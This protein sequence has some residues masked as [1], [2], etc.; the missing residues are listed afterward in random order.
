MFFLLVTADAKHQNSNSQLKLNSSDKKSLER[1]RE[2]KCENKTP[3]VKLD[4]YAVFNCDI[5]ECVLV[6][7]L[8]RNYI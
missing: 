3:R 8:S 6:T 1:N 7:L 2:Y 4:F 5:N